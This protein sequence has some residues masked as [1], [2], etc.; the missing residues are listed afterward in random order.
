V[1]FEISPVGESSSAKPAGVPGGTN[2]DD[3]DEKESER[4]GRKRRRRGGRRR[5]RKNGEAPGAVPG[6]GPAPLAASAEPGN[7]A[8][9]ATWRRRCRRRRA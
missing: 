1:V 2:G 4:G 5:K 8:D 3:E 6:V 7:V 9:G